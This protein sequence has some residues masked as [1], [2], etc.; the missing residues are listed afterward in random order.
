MDLGIRQRGGNAKAEIHMRYAD[1]TINGE[2]VKM[3]IRPQN[4]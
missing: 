1:G 3:E 2:V 4:L